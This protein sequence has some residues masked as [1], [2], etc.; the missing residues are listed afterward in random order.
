LPIGGTDLARAWAGQEQRDVD[1]P[2][3]AVHHYVQSRHE[4]SDKA[5]PGEGVYR[6]LSHSFHEA[7]VVAEEADPEQPL[8]KSQRPHEGTPSLTEIDGR[9]HW[10]GRGVDGRDG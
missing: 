1:F 4:V 8:A 5:R 10:V 2:Q 6:H 9:V 3:H 7:P